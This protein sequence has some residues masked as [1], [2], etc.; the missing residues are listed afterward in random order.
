MKED[1]CQSPPGANVIPTRPDCGRA[2]AREGS[3]SRAAASR[4]SRRCPSRPTTSGST[5]TRSRAAPPAPPSSPAR[6]HAEEARRPRAPRPTR[7]AKLDGSARRELRPSRVRP[8][9]VRQQRRWRGYQCYLLESC[10]S[11]DQTRCSGCRRRRR[12]RCRRHASRGLK[13]GERRGR[14]RW[15]DHGDDH[16]S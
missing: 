2:L 11:G 10:G 13:G 8:S 4:S 15:G 12:L 6:R 7:C 1:N 16:G 14:W 3:P 5:R 9:R